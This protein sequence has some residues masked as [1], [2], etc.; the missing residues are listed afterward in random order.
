MSVLLI[1]VG[2]KPITVEAGHIGER[3]FWHLFQSV[4][5]IDIIASSH[6]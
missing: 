1:F 5:D 3:A 4:T 2:H 6:R